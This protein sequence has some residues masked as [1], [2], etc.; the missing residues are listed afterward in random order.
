MAQISR[1]FILF[2][3]HNLE[4]IEQKQ[5]V[6]MKRRIKG[7]PEMVVMY[8]DMMYDPLQGGLLNRG[9]FFMGPSPLLW[10]VSRKIGEN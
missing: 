8:T 1:M 2:L 9:L 10:A 7:R 5:W 3:R 4:R 6:K